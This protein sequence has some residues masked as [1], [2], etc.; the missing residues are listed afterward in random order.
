MLE[1]AARQGNEFGGK[2]EDLKEIMA[3]VTNKGRLGICLDTC[4]IFAAGYDIR[5]QAAYDKTM[6]EFDRVI[7]LQH[8]KAVHLN[9]SKGE[10]CVFGA[11]QIS[12]DSL[13]G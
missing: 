1:T 3:R 10:N 7:G 2:F 5:T 12:S 8:L 4:H 13:V 9:D 11:T 6:E